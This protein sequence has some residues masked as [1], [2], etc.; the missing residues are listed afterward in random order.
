MNISAISYH[1]ISAQP[2]FLLCTSEVERGGFLKSLWKKKKSYFSLYHFIS[3]QNNF[4]LLSSQQG[5]P[6][7]CKGVLPCF[8]GRDEKPLLCFAPCTPDTLNRIKD[9]IYIPFVFHVWG[10]ETDSAFI[11]CERW[12]ILTFWTF[13][14][15]DIKG[16]D[17][18][19]I[20]GER[21]RVSLS[22]FW[23]NSVLIA[24]HKSPRFRS[25]LVA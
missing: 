5:A 3:L 2:L 23:Y 13:V 24:C 25:T 9:D 17:D 15:K 1:S 22:K 18:W 14:E 11:L 21:W 8:I 12:N 7:S 10:A 6:M 16:M 20:E 19:R 4:F